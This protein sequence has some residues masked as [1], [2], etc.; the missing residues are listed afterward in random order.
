VGPQL[1][2]VGIDDL[3]FLLD[4]DREGVLHPAAIIV[5]EV[6]ISPDRLVA[7][8]TFAI[9]LASPAKGLLLVAVLA[10]LGSADAIAAAFIAGWVLR[11]VP[12][13]SGPRMAAPLA[14][15]LLCALVAGSSVG[16]NL[17]PEGSAG[18]V[19]FLLGAALA[20]ATVRIF[21]V[22]PDLSIEL[23]AAL[24]AGG[25]G[26]LA[27]AIGRDSAAD[28][29]ALAAASGLVAC[30]AAG[31][32]ARARGRA[33]LI[34]AAAG[35]AL[36]AGVVLAACR[37]PQ[38][39]SA[40]SRTR[41]LIAASVRAAASSPW[42]GIGIGRDRTTTPLFYPASIAWHGGALGSHNLL[43]IGVEL[44]LVGLALWAIWIG[45]GFL[46][47]ARALVR[48]SHDAR[49]WGAAGGA[50][51]YVAALAV[52]R[53][54]AFSET[55]FPFLIQFGLMTGLAGSTLLDATP[56]PTRRTRWQVAVTAIAMAATAA[57]AFISARRGPPA[58]TGMSTP[59]ATAATLRSR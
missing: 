32:S 30:L 53:P 8:F 51:F 54:L 6:A 35:I 7:V 17:E 46:R 33:R 59:A 4:A 21:R 41:P 43:A 31:M 12:D 10:P 25:C 26:A 34:W 20:A 22:R 50:A 40:L 3:E 57:G 49:L 5:R 27:L 15:G 44:G 45:A 37:S 19:R 28:W 9:A 42:F 29:R 58:Q 11:G 1:P 48:D 36:F 13:R 38:M 16:V 56:A 18:A 47:A 23:P 14:A 24:A 39:L 52:G 55:A 2:R